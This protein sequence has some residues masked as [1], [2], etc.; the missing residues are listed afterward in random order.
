LRAT[1]RCPNVA[2]N[3]RGVDFLAHPIVLN[4]IGM[5]LILGMSWLAKYDAVIQCSKRAVQL[6]APSGEKIEYQAI[7][8]SEVGQGF[9][10]IREGH[11]EQ[12]HSCVQG[13]VT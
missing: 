7:K 1:L 8:S 12:G 13:N 2:I 6:V 3:I 9:G 5:D 10:G 4:S 11:Q